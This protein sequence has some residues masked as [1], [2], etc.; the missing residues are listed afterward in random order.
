MPFSVHLDSKFDGDELAVTA[1]LTNCGEV[2]LRHQGLAASFDGE[3]PELREFGA[4]QPPKT[5]QHHRRVS[6]ITRASLDEL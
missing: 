6:S 5:D 1:T 4:M 3:G 2:P